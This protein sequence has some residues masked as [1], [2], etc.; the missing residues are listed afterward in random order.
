MAKK[1]DSDRIH[2]ITGDIT[3]LDVDAIVNAANSSL[4][5]GGGVDGAIHSRGGPEILKA[6][7]EIRDNHFPGG[8]PQGEA[9]ITGG[10]RLKARY[11]IHTVGPVWSGGTSGEAEVLANAYQNSLNVAADNNIESVAF[12]AISTGVYGYPKDLAGAIA[13]S[14]VTAFLS[15]AEI[16]KEVYFVFFSRGDT[17]AFQKAISGLPGVKGR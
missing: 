13:Y 5:G 17:A 1:H 12:P 9:V 15:E 2:V 16:P 11:V 8:L 3:G 14:T 10:G 4:M 7:K 6:C